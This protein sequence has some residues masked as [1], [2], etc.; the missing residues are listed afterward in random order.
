[1]KVGDL[2]MIKDNGVLEGQLALV[3]REVSNNLRLSK[4]Y[5]I[6]AVGSWYW[7]P[8]LPFFQHQLEIINE[9]R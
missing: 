9:S 7:P 4:R 6:S 2:V 3:V 1:M 8:N 5:N